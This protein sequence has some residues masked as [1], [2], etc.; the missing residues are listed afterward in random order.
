MAKYRVLVI[1]DAKYIFKAVKMALEPKGFE[2]VGHAENG[3]IGLEMYDQLRPDVVTL[4][5]T[6]PVMDGIET[7][8]L[9]CKKEPEAKIVMVSAITDEGLRK[10]AMDA[11]VKYFAPKPFQ[12][13]ELVSKVLEC[14]SG[15]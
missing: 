1:D 13:D 6:M 11:G 7:A 2:V 10:S 8:T 3:K 15:T 5:V 12:P 9:L 4:D 14:L